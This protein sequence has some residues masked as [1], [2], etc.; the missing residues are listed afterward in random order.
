MDPFAARAGSCTRAHRIAHWARRIRRREL[1]SVSAPARRRARRF[2]CR[3]RHSSKNLRETG[4]KNRACAPASSLVAQL[5]KRRTCSS[6][7]QVGRFVATCTSW[8]KSDASCLP[9]PRDDAVRFADQG[10]TVDSVK[11]SLAGRPL[12]RA[13]ARRQAGRDSHDL[14]GQPRAIIGCCCG[15]AARDL[16]AQRFERFHNCGNCNGRITRL[17]P[18]REVQELVDRCSAQRR[19]NHRLRPCGPAFSFLHWAC[20]HRRP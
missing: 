3:C 6:R 20:L 11:S 2:R 7:G 13:L 4:K 15:V 17:L 9:A 10:K 1:V 12:L 19:G 16:S 5:A 18:P 14:L 8:K